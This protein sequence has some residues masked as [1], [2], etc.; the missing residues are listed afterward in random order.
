MYRRTRRSHC[1]DRPWLNS[2]V[3]MFWSYWLIG[4]H[5]WRGNPQ[6]WRRNI[7][8]RSEGEEQQEGTSEEGLGWTS[9]HPHQPRV[10]KGREGTQFSSNVSTVCTW[11]LIVL[12]KETRLG[13]TAESFQR[14]G[15]CCSSS[16]EQG[17]KFYDPRKESYNRRGFF[18]G[19][20]VYDFLPFVTGTLVSLSSL[21]NRQIKRV[22]VV[23]VRS[24]WL[25]LISFINQVTK[26]R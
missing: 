20:W 6:Y 9:S 8:E 18:P 26:K 4:W 3:K 11:L 15:H 23:V 10:T 19:Q 5:C 14:C 16:R 22:T 25:M 2:L 24:S 13:L 12:A 17:R 7:R 21:T 1:T